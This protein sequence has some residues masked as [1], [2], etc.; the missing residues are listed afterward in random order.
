M[1]GKKNYVGK[2]MIVFFFSSYCMVVYYCRSS[3]CFSLFMT[4]VWNLLLLNKRKVTF[5]LICVL[6]CQACIFFLLESC[7][8]LCLVN[9]QNVKFSFNTETNTEIITVFMCTINKN[10]VHVNV[11]HVSVYKTNTDYNYQ[12]WDTQY[13]INK[14]C[15]HEVGFL[16]LYIH[17]IFPY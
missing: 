4:S 15:I 6:I 7:L 13:T 17:L 10:C 14:N 3:K 2:N 5:R 1:I 9:S 12:S 8:G 11:L 16:C